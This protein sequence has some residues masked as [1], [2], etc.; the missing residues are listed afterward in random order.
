MVKRLMLAVALAV[1]VVSAG[2]V[3]AYADDDGGQKDTVVRP[4]TFTIAKG[5]CPA[6]PG[7]LEI[8]GQGIERTKTRITVGGDEDD[9]D[10]EDQDDEEGDENRGGIHFS[11]STRITGTA[12]DNLGGRYKFTYRLRGTSPIPGSGIAID[13]FK[14]T[15]KGAADGLSTFFRARVTFDSNINIIGFEFLETAGDPAHCDPL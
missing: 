10:D 13:T 3:A 4:R 2:A 9:A 1:L 11:I 15:G 14:L 7:N 5:Q 6:L 8:N 12:T